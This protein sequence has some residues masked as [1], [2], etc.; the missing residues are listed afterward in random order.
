MSQEA[1]KRYE[2]ASSEKILY[3][4][5]KKAL[6]ESEPNYFYALDTGT[7]KTITSIHHYL[8]YS[9]GEKLLIIAPPAKKKEG[10]WDRDIELIEETYSLKIP[11]QVISYG[12]LAKTPIPNEPYFIIFDEAHY[13]KNPTSKRGKQGMRLAKASTHFC[14]LTATP[15]A[16]GWEDSINY[17]IMFGFVKNKTQFNR[18]HAVFENIKMGNISFPKIVGWRNEDQLKDW[19]KSFTVTISKKEALDLPPLFKQD[20]HFNPSKEYKI[21]QK[22]RVLDDEAYDTLPKLM[23]GL[24]F[25]A[26]QKD[27]LDWCKE[28]LEGTSQNIA[29]FY[30]YKS[31]YEELLSICQKLGKKVYAVNGQKSNLPKKEEWKNLKNSVTLIQYQAGSS[32]IE[33]QYCTEVI[34]YTPTYSYQDY[35]QSLGRAYRNGQE[36]KVTVYRFKTK[37]T[38][39]EAVWKALENKKDFD[40]KLY[41]ETRLNNV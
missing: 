35:T 31:E 27:K 19:Y 13:I 38:I 20:I 30:Q 6:D 2:T 41:Q 21:L 32:G 14:L 23:H 39:E 26:N 25:Y 16:N 4:F 17:F 10:G 28:M 7:G 29:I 3:K 11:Y 9:N 33:L 8:K 37:N 5:Q 34:F 36:S 1:Y 22:D 12:L 15:M 40:E 24:R 18:E